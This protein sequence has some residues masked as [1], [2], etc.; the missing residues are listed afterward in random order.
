MLSRTQRNAATW[1]FSPKLPG[2]AASP[3]LRKPANNEFIY[4]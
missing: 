2:A 4:F 1:S 3:V